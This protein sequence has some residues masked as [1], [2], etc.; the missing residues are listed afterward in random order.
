MSLSFRHR[1]AAALAVVATG[2]VAAAAPV[3]VPASAAGVGPVLAAEAAVA[4]A[5]LPF[6]GATTFA[7]A[8]GNRK[9]YKLMGDPV[10][11][12]NPCDVIGYRFNPAR[13]PK[14]ALTDLKGAVKRV[15]AATGLRFVYRG[16]TSAVPRANEGYND[17]YPANTQLV[18][19]WVKPGKQSEWMPK[20]GPAGVGG[21]VWS[22]AW[23]KSGK[24]QGMISWGGVVLNTDVKVVG[25]FGTGPKYGWQGTRGQL[26]MHELGHAIGLAH[27]DIDDQKQI[28]Y[29]QMS[30]KKA[31][32]GAGDLNGL[33]LV[34]KSGGCMTNNNPVESASVPAE[35][36]SSN[37]AYAA[38]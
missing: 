38:W 2:G 29:P 17:E 10:A 3:T 8:A 9:A 11:R 4:Q 33:K 35:A 36:A 13:A 19:A 27:P 5:M 34:G 28:M 14:G 25:G 18:V 30:R 32:W 37:G 26:L 20:N 7:A 6:S 22:P 31:V 1:L 16:T 23:T 21:S 12:W 24:E 15:S